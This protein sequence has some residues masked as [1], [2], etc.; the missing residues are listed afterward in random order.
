M[1][2]ITGL[3]CI[4][5]GIFV[6]FGCGGDGETGTRGG[7][8][9]SDGY[10]VDREPSKGGSLSLAGEAGTSAEEGGASSEDGGEFSAGGSETSEGG[11][12]DQG[13]GGTTSAE[14]GASSQAG[15]AGEATYVPSCLMPG[16]NFSP[17][18]DSD[19]DARSTAS[20]I[21][22]EELTERIS[23]VAPYTNWIRTFA[24]NADLAGAGSIAHELGKNMAMGV[25]IASDATANDEQIVCL[26][27]AIANGD[28]DTAIVGSEVLLRGDLEE[29][30]LIT[31]I[32]TVKACA[33]PYNVP[34]AYADV[35]GELLSAPNVISEIDLV[36][37]NYYPYWEGKSVDQAIAY[38]HRW[39]RQLVSASGGKEVIV[40]E[41]GWPSCGDTLGE[42]VPSLENAGLYFLNFVSW[43]D[44]NQVTYFYF[45]A[46]DEGW[47]SAPEGAQ[48]A[49]WGIWDGEMNLKAG[50][51]PVF[52]CERME[53]NWTEVEVDTPIIDFPELPETLTT[54]LSH[55]FVSGSS[56][57]GQ[58]VTVNGTALPVTAFNENGTFATTVTLVEGVNTIE[59]VTTS[60]GVTI[61]D[62]LKTI[63]YDPVYSTAD[64]R[65]LYVDVTTVNENAP[66]V[67]GTVVIDVDT[68]VVLGILL[69]H[70]IVGIAPNGSEIY[71]ADRIVVDTATHRFSRTLPFTSNLVPNGTIVSPDGTRI[72]AGVE[73]VD[74][75]T[76]ALLEGSLPQSVTLQYSWASEPIPGG[77]GISPDGTRIYWDGMIVIDTQSNALL[78][79]EYL[80]YFSS[81]FLGD[82]T[83]TPDGSTV[84][85]SL[86]SYASGGIAL[87]DALTFE[88]KVVLEEESIGDYAGEIVFT[89]D[90][91]FMIVGSSGNSSSAVDGRVTVFSM[92]DY[93]ILSQTALPLSA[94]L[95]VSSRNEVFVSSGEAGLVSKAGVNVYALD[96]SN[97]SLVLAK[98]YGLS[99]NTW[100]YTT[101][102]TKNHQI[103]RIF[104]KE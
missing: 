19:E 4:F 26:C 25:W 100:E 85:F 43:A 70:H 14:A 35:Y 40:S 50:M 15:S 48:G 90:G 94:N 5:V 37:A 16:V 62:T 86:Y 96:T 38:V 51:Q 83:V 95:V 98:T 68:D 104:L 75:L 73:C 54:N 79:S 99:I 89:D 7:S 1:K 10:Y 61:S 32:Q 23:A 11:S 18:I 28:V 34:V 57:V 63:V 17:Y 91:A 45:S 72:Y 74:V 60:E 88:P 65:L 21:T 81:P 64:K 101:G 103:R 87:Y 29:S 55:Y 6:I 31:L 97:G 20:Q 2:Q 42:A 47:K 8:S 33:E 102:F 27:D 9:G 69:N 44:A 49:C 93:A 66:I 12:S 58:T 56:E 52:D 30:D 76:N 46:F 59:V 3:L 80:S 78:Q 53:D 24:C 71:F 92:S 82:V 84:A 36:Y 67:E 77:S 13:N 22:T 41:T 39:H